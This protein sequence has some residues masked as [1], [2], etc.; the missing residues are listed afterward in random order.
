M[1][2]PFDEWLVGR[3]LAARSIAEYCKWV[4]RAER[5]CWVQ[6]L[7]LATLTPPQ[8]RAFAD[9]TPPSWS[10]RK[11]VRASLGH[12]Y[13]WVGRPDPPHDA[14]P[15]PRKPGMATRALTPGDA[16]SLRDAAVLVGGRHG[17]ATL[18]SVA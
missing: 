13:G 5:W 15:V 2:L 14:V 3:G 11:Q 16:R 4:R 8:V 10:T 12:Y 6:R 18:A 1:T 9:T 17:L 7:D